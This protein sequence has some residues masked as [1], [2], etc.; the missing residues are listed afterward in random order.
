M[1]FKCGGRAGIPQY[2]PHQIEERVAKV[3]ERFKTLP[4][5]HP[6]HVSKVEE[7]TLIA[8]IPLF[9][10]VETSI[11]RVPI[12]SAV[13]HGD[14]LEKNLLFSTKTSKYKWFDF[15]DSS[16]I[17]PF[18][19]LDMIMDKRSFPYSDDTKKRIIDAYLSEWKK[20]YAN[21]YSM[22]ELRMVFEG[23]IW[24]A[25]IRRAEIRL[26]IMEITTAGQ[27]GE[28]ASYGKDELLYAAK[29]LINNDCFL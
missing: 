27:L 11:E 29:L 4:C 22:G 26:S 10:E 15:G 23:A 3:I 20:Y 1:I 13:D 7:E 9:S 24:L 2:H 12:D 5:E 16:W 19:S 8:A 25:A 6:S 28:M 17:H 21:R 14:L 18:V